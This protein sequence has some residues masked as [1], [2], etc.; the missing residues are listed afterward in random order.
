MIFF[1][2]ISSTVEVYGMYGETFMN[3]A[4]DLASFTGL[5]HT[6]ERKYSYNLYNY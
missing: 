3:F 4:L 2:R 1:G 5:P 6:K